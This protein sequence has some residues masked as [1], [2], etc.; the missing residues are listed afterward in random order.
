M[1]TQLPENFNQPFG[2]RNRFQDLSHRLPPS[3]LRPN[4]LGQS[5]DVPSR[6]TPP[7][8][9]IFSPSEGYHVSAGDVIVKGYAFTDIWREIERVELSLDDGKTWVVADLSP[10]PQPGE[11][12]LWRKHF[13]L[14]PGPYTLIVRAADN[15]PDKNPADVDLTRH[16]VSFEVVG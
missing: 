11:W 2:S 7:T 15:V 6:N 16:Q 14:T 8:V 4:R 10:Y 5:V 12:R 9:F 13:T 3:Y 1:A